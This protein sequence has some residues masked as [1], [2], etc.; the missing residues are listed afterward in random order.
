MLYL[1]LSLGNPQKPEINSKKL[2]THTLYMHI[3]THTR[4]GSH[5]VLPPYSTLYVYVL[6]GKI[7]QLNN[8]VGQDRK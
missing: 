7:T 8:N 6:H 4:T 5:G 2:A 3:H 1:N